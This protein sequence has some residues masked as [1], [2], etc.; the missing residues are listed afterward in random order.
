MTLAEHIANIRDTLKA[1]GRAERRHH[2]ACK[3]AFEECGPDL[4]SNGEFVA[5]GGG[6]GD[7]D[8]ED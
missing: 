4:L 1:L 7:K 3:A 8:D 5:L 2:R 6:T